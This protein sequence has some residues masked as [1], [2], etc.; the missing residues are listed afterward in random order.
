MRNGLL[1]YFLSYETGT[2]FF[3]SFVSPVKEDSSTEILFPSINI[4]ST[5]KI[6]PV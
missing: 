2:D 1:P 4:P 6:Y 3:T 5:D